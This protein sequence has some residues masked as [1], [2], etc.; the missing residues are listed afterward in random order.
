MVTL[1]ALITFS[2]AGGMLTLRYFTSKLHFL[3][4]PLKGERTMAQQVTL[5]GVE[6]RSPCISV[7]LLILLQLFIVDVELDPVAELAVREIISSLGL[8]VVGWYHSHPQFRPDPSVTDIHNQQQYQTLMRDE[9]SGLEPFIGL[10][11]STFDEKLPSVESHHQWFHTRPYADGARGKKPVSIPMLLDVDIGVYVEPH[12]GVEAFLSEEAT[13]E[14]IQRLCCLSIAST[15]DGSS[16]SRDIEARNGIHSKVKELPQ[17][18]REQD[19]HSMDSEGETG[20]CDTLM[21]GNKNQSSISFPVPMHFAGSGGPTHLDDSLVPIIAVKRKYTKRVADLVSDGAN[22]RRS[23]RETKAPVMFVP[24]K[25]EK[26]K[27]PSV[28]AEKAP[29][30][31]PPPVPYSVPPIIAKSTGKIR[32]KPG[33][34]KGSISSAKRRIDTQVQYSAP[35]E[36]GGVFV[37]AIGKWLSAGAV[38]VKPAIIQAVPAKRGK[39]AVKEEVVVKE[40][41]KAVTNVKKRQGPGA[42]GFKSLYSVPT[43]HPLPQPIVFEEEP[44]APSGSTARVVKRKRDLKSPVKA[45]KKP[46]LVQCSEVEPKSDKSKAG[47]KSRKD[48]TLKP[49]KR[50]KKEVNSVEDL[51]N[52]DTNINGAHEAEKEAEKEV[53]SVTLLE[54]LQGPS[55][56]A[57]TGRHL[58]CC[59]KPAYRCLALGTA[60]LGFYYSTHTRRVSLGSVWRDGISKSDKLKGSITYWASRLGINSSSQI[61]LV[62]SIVSFLL[63][64]WSE[65]EGQIHKEPVVAQKKKRN[66]AHDSH[67]CSSHIKADGKLVI[68]REDDG[69]DDGPKKKKKK[70][71]L[72]NRKTGSSSRIPHLSESSLDDLTTSPL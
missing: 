61:C 36:Q 47:A 27:I 42:R 10:I 35:K 1:F 18:R 50:I 13:E 65:G 39:Y 44:K 2:Q 22:E 4:H 49:R 11:V 17:W 31:P 28:A 51:N 23:G 59:M 67:N 38:L 30:P 33:P 8:I 55:E 12:Q 15:V 16:S 64:S 9:V 62:D 14:L 6:N 43:N 32:K 54:L 57:S 48:S 45:G 40:A 25:D 21:Q 69:R 63:L 29:P 3:A 72:K 52:E 26:V 37:G 7:I 68:Y 19:D 60:T 20:E 58:V 66:T 46:T 34:A 71:S 41:V 70:K 56:A 24:E 53:V 5:K